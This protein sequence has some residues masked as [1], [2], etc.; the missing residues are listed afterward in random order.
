MIFVGKNLEYLV[1]CIYKNTLTYIRYCNLS[2]MIILGYNYPIKQTHYN[3]IYLVIYVSL[4]VPDTS[5]SRVRL[6]CI[7]NI[8]YCCLNPF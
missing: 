6:H 8:C 2:N 7:T 1:F 3:H 4:F 5:F